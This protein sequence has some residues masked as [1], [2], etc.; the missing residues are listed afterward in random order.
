MDPTRKEASQNL[1]GQGNLWASRAD[2][3]AVDQEVG[4]PDQGRPQGA[5]EISGGSSVTTRPMI[6]R[7]AHKLQAAGPPA[8]R[9][10]RRL[11]VSSTKPSGTR[12][13]TC[14]ELGRGPVRAARRAQHRGPARRGFAVTFTT[15]PD[16]PTASAQRVSEARCW[17]TPSVTTVGGAGPPARDPQRTRAAAR[18]SGDLSR[19]PLPG[20][21]QRGDRRPLRPTLAA[22]GSRAHRDAAQQVKMFLLRC[23][24]R[25]N[26]GSPVPS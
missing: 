23:R 22:L 14:A 21:L 8:D 26:P 6:D 20:P 12:A 11:W 2:A 16:P 15:D 9:R 7:L 5:G 18:A 3:F 1:A 13:T 25:T 10:G 24:W 19:P 4:F 17:S